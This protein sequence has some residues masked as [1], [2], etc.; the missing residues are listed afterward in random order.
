MSDSQVSVGEFMIQGKSL[1]KGDSVVWREMTSCGD[2]PCPRR[3][4][5]VTSLDGRVIVQGGRDFQGNVL[6]D[7]I[8]FDPHSGMWTTTYRS[9]RQVC[10][11][12]LSERL[13]C[14][15]LLFI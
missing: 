4:F 1:S 15:S 5:C 7:I 2:V 14:S 12:S 3:D 9:D 6:D 13:S 8:S 11:A 10:L